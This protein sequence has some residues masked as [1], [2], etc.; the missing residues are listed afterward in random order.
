MTNVCA[1]AVILAVLLTGGC[2]DARTIVTESDD[3]AI[4]TAYATA[5]AAPEMSSVYFTVINRGGVEDTLLAVRSVGTAELHTVE[6]HDG[7]SSMVPVAALPV[8]GH[9]CVILKPGSY[10]VMLRRL[11]TPLAAGDSIDVS[12]DMAL[13][14][15]LEMRIPVL[16]YTDVVELVDAA[17][18]RC[19]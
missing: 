16:T 17:G 6:T 8:P 11:P 3:I 13:A 10:H 1:P 7:L 12:L 2:A 9:T 4:A 14:G 19:P 5:S 15:T 18:E